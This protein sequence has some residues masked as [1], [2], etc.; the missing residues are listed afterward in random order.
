MFAAV[1]LGSN[2]F[3]LHIGEPAGE[4]M[5]IVH[6]AHV[7]IRWADGPDHQAMASATR[8]ALQCLAEFGALLKQHPLQAAR[9]V[10][11]GTVRRGRN[12]AMFLPLAE[13]AL[14]YPIEIISREE[15]GRLVYMGVARATAR[16]G[17]RRLV[18]DIG[19]ASSAIVHGQGDDIDAVESFAIGAERQGATFFADGRVDAASFAA[20][21]LS[22]RARLQDAAGLY[23]ARQWD[24]VYGASGMV[25]SIGEL[26]AAAGRELRAQDLCLLRDR[27]LAAGHVSTLAGSGVAAER[28]VALA[29]GLAV[30]LGMMQEL[31][32]GQVVP[33]EAGLRLGLLSDLERQ[34][35][36]D[37]RRDASVQ[38]F[39]RRFAVDRDRARRSAAT[40]RRFY[41]Q[42]GPDSDQY[43]RLLEW[44][45][46]LQELGQAVSY[47]GAQRHAAYIIEHA[48][49]AGFTARELRTMGTLVLAQKGDL[50]QVREQLADADLAKAVLALRL[51]GICVRADADHDAGALELR[52][53]GGIDLRAPAAWFE[54]HPTML[55]WLE[56]ED[57]RWDEVGVPLR[58]RRMVDASS[59]AGGLIR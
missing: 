52:M 20:A 39:M 7:P 4:A 8:E 12:T 55:W 35:N 59:N 46:L 18:V 6:T 9:A 49:L 43:R 13:K 38:A 16:P 34:A 36:R 22:T 44:A 14:G 27:L 26:A 54:R 5:R 2:G 40:A 32:V 51:A 31:G 42:L 58:V 37:D 48:D 47:S 24:V 15:E 19:S 29:G 56:Q 21:V 17:E 33:V 50:G 3:R 41:E 28:A 25:R 10:A 1:E 53:R 30:L 11:T 57:E 23:R 45:C